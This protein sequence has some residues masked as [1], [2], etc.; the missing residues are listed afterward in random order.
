MDTADL[1]GLYDELPEH[2]LEVSRASKRAAIRAARTLLDRDGRRTLQKLQAREARKL[3]GYK[4]LSP[5]AKHVHRQLLR[6]ARTHSGEVFKNERALCTL[7][8]PAPTK[9]RPNQSGHI[10]RSTLRAALAELEQ[11]GV[12]TYWKTYGK[13]IGAIRTTPIKAWRLCRTAWSRAWATLK[14]TAVN[15]YQVRAGTSLGW[16]R[17]SRGRDSGVLDVVQDDGDEPLPVAPTA[18]HEAVRRAQARGAG[19]GPAELARAATC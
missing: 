10:H 15:M 19:G 12:W 16:N 5:N 8:P 1:Y 6:L 4:T 11:A 17:A 14:H 13:R 9:R 2:E 7:I 3:P 18:I